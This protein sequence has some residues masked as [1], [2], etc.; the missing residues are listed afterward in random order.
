MAKR[1]AAMSQARLLEA[2]NMPAPV[3]DG[4]GH[5]TPQLSSDAALVPCFINSAT[6]HLIEPQA[7]AC[8]DVRA[9]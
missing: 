2:Y 5:D 3:F 6:M 1:S 4:L 9:G 8:A 7:L